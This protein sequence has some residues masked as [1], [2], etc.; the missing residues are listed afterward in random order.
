MKF[1]DHLSTLLGIKHIKFYSDSFKYD[2]YYIMTRGEY[3]FLD[4]VH[5][6]SIKNKNFSV[7][8]LSN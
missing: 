7:I 3:F 2:F 4:N 5:S 1:G 8:T 6:V